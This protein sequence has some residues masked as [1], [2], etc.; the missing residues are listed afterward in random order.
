ML[1]P[2]LDLQ[3]RLE[4]VDVIVGLTAGLLTVEIKDGDGLM[5]DVCVE[6]HH[7]PGKHRLAGQDH[8]HDCT[9]GVLRDESDGDSDTE[10]L[11]VRNPFDERPW[12]HDSSTTPNC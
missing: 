1:R 9:A 11:I 12:S 6:G 10:R 3:K 7:H 4:V 2:G 5:G 8:D